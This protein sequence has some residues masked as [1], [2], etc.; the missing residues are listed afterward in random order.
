MSYEIVETS[1]VH[2]CMTYIYLTYPIHYIQLVFQTQ[3][4]L[5]PSHPVGEDTSEEK[6]RIPANI[7]IDSEKEDEEDLFA[8]I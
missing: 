3:E 7:S 1:S 2:Y 4:P 8:G 5:L 6:T